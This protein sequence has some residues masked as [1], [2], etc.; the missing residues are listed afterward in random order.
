MQALKSYKK[1][2]ACVRLGLFT[3]AVRIIFTY[4]QAL[5]SISFAI[6]QITSI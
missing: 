2:I 6:L 3:I 4:G 5:K 1:C